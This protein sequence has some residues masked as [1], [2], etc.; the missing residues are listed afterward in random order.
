MIPFENLALSNK[1]FEEGFKR[2]FQD[3]ITEG[4]YILGSRLEKFE[5]EFAEFNQVPYC[6]GVGNGLDALV[7][8]LRALNLEPG[9]EV[10]VPSNT[11]IASI[12]AIL[13]VGLKPVLVEPS[14]ESYTI[15]PNK[16]EDSISPNTGA[17]MVVHL[18]GKCC[19]MDKI[20]SISKKHQLPIIEDAAQAHGARFKNELAGTWG[21]LNCFSFY[22]TKNLGSLGDGGAILTREENLNSHIRSLRNYGSSKK[23]YNEEIGVNS[24]LDDLQACFLS[25]KLPFLEEMNAHRRK[26][27]SIYKNELRSDFITPVFHPDYWDVFHIFNIRHPERDRLKSYLGDKGIGTEIHYPVSPNCQPALK[28]LFEKEEFPISEEIHKTTLSLP[29]SICHD[30]NQIHEIIEVMNR[31]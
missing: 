19:E 26:L 29:C 11:F 18:Y 25:V 9:S 16:I 5:I 1:T 17:I 3:F 27:A 21:I 30:E 14:L 13:Q 22:P 2:A 6:I 20:L 7:L 28:S 15:D 23:Y 10:I 24:R 8:S 12:L 4:R 31:F